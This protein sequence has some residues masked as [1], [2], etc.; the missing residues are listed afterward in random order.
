MGVLYIYPK[1]KTAY[2]FMFDSDLTANQ[3]KKRIE[4]G[5]YAQ[6][7]NACHDVYHCNEMTIEYCDTPY[8]EQTDEFNYD[9]EN[10]IFK[11]DV[12]YDGD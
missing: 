5:W 2:S 7:V 6:V 1:G 8:D 11:I 12:N 9:D 3:A 10:S 4:T